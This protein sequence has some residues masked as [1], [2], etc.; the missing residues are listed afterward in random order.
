[1]LAFFVK[2]N[3]LRWNEQNTKDTAINAESWAF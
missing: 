2:Y 3:F 1:M